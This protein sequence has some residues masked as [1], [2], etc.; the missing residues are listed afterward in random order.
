VDF[1]AKGYPFAIGAA[2]SDADVD[3]LSI[4][5]TSNSSQW[6]DIIKNFEDVKLDVLIIRS[7]NSGWS[8]GDYNSGH[9]RRIG[10]RTWDIPVLGESYF[11]TETKFGQPTKV[12]ALSIDKYFEDRPYRDGGDVCC[13]PPYNGSLVVDPDQFLNPVSSLTVEDQD[14]DGYMDKKEDSNRSGTLDGDRIDTDVSTWLD[15]NIPNRLNPFNINNNTLIEL[16]QQ[17]GDSVPQ[18]G[19]YEKATVFRHVITH[20]LGHAVGMGLGD[21]GMVD[22]LGHCFDPSCVMYQYSTNWDRDGHF[23]PYHQQLIRIDNSV[24]SN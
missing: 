13:D 17:K 15:P 12:Y 2:F 24:K 10:I 14:D 21:P 7:Y 6:N 20:E 18:N 23:C 5:T 4:Q 3:M 1:A 22:N 16:P 9:I 11:G 19:E 8:G